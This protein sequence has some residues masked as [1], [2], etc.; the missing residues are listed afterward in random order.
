MQKLILITIL[1][2][3]IVGCNMKSQEKIDHNE[4][5]ELHEHQGTENYEVIEVVVN[6]AEVSDFYGNSESP[7]IAIDTIAKTIMIGAYGI[8]E[9]SNHISGTYITDLLGNT[10]KRKRVLG[11]VL[12]EGTIWEITNYSNLL[13]N[14]DT[15]KHKF[16]DPFSDKK[17]DQPLE[18]IVNEKD[19]E[20]WLDKFKELYVK[21]QYVFIWESLGYYY[22][23]IDDKWYFLSNNFE[24][25]INLEKQ[26]PAKEDQNVRLV[27][28]KNLAPIFYYGKPEKLD[29]H[30]IKRIDYE[31]I[32][33]KEVDKGLN[34]YNFSAGW[35]YLDIY[36]PLGDTIRIKRYSNYEDPELMLYKIPDAYGG[37][38]D[39][40]FIVQ[41]PEEIFPNQVGGMYAIRPR[42]PEQPQRRYKSIV[43]HKNEKG[44][45]VIDS[46]KSEETAA[47]KTWKVKKK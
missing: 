7:K 4:F 34:Q 6:K 2:L 31:S 26:Y 1:T 47:Y 19:P 5:K 23:K 42:D 39:V 3:N 9:N 22:F 28:L 35:W 16:I 32:Y 36:M 38:E 21:A 13:V 41:N 24:E 44:E 29:T 17:I 18:F 46:E 40:L 27:E 12:K 37:R 33:F 30:L 45:R 10:L 25:H 14:G 15:A 43:Y 11:R 20:K 8:K